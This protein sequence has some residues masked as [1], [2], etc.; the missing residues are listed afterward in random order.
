MSPSKKQQHVVE[1]HDSSDD[2]APEA[3][4][5]ESAKEIAVQMMRDYRNAAR[6][7]PK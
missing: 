6:S 7:Q 1:H 4:T 5:K 3:F 2:E